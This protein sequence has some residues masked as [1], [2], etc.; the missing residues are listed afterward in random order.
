MLLI[1]I[2]TYF[3]VNNMFHLSRYVILHLKSSCVALIQNKTLPEETNEFKKFSHKV[4]FTECS[5]ESTFQLCLSL[6]IY[7][8]FGIS[9]DYYSR[10]IQLSSLA[11]SLISVCLEFAKVMMN[12]LQ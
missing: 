12:I 7:R 1:E 8:E 4:A 9:E 3:N 11:T 5:T 6:A 10:T 2:G